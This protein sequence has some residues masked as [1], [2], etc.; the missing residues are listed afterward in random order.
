[1]DA[2]AAARMTPGVALRLGRVSNLPTVWTNVLAALALAGAPLFEAATLALVVA[3][4]CF[5]VGGMYLNDGFDSAIDARERPD[6]PIPSGQVKRRTVM[7]IG[8]T[9]LALGVALVAGTA[10]WLGTSPGL[11]A[12]TGLGLAGA[13]VLYDLWHKDNPISPVLMGLNR[14]L[15]YGAA[16]V[17]A[18]GAWPTQ[19]LWVAALLLCYVIGLTYAAKQEHLA[20]IGSVWPLAF[21]AAPFVVLAVQLPDADTNAVFTAAIFLAWVGYAVSLLL[22]P[23]PEV[24]QAVVSLIA[25]ICLFDATWLA[26]VDAPGASALAFAAFFLTLALQRFVPGT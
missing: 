5:Y 21:L 26:L 18:T 23:E 1:M 22:R 7:A 2:G 17:A 3:M 11:G 15:V 20:R 13:I 9:A 16:A 8:F 4:S 24:P 10:A 25:G 14:M 19:A 12:L 6:R